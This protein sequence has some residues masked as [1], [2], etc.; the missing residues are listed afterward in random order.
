[1][2]YGYVGDT[3][4]WHIET[5]IILIPGYYITTGVEFCVSIGDGLVLNMQHAIT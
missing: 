4:T 5:W 3:Y 2:T 1:M